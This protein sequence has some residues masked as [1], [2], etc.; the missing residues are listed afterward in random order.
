MPISKFWQL[1]ILGLHVSGFC[2]LLSGPLVGHTTDS[3]ATLWAY[4]GEGKQVEFRYGI[5]GT[6]LNEMT[7]VLVPP[8]PERHFISRTD[9][10]GLTSGVAYQ[11]TV[12]VDGDSAGAGSFTTA[13]APFQPVEFTFLVASCIDRGIDNV[14]TTWDGAHNEM[15]AFSVLL[16]DNVYS[17]S[18]DR[19]VIWTFNTDQ[20]SI[21][22]FANVIRNFPTYAIWDDHD[23]ADNDS[24]GEAVGKENSYKAFT[25]L[26]ANPYYGVPPDTGIYFN[27]YWGNVQ[28]FMLDGRY[29]RSPFSAPD[30]EYKT[31]LGFTQR[32]W[33]FNELKASRAVFKFISAGSTID[34]RDDGWRNYLTELGIIHNYI[35]S[36][37]IY[38]VVWLSGD[39]HENYFK[40]YSPDMGYTVNEI[41]SSGIS[42]EERS[43][44]YIDVNTKAAVPTFTARLI[45]QEQVMETKTLTLADLSSV[46]TRA[47]QI[48][49]P[50][51]GQQVQ[52]AS[53]QDINWTTIGTIDNVKLAYSLGGVWNTIQPSLSNTGIYS[54]LVPDDVSA[55]VRISVSNLD[56]SAADT[57]DVFEIIS[58]M[59]LISSENGNHSF[60]FS[61]LGQN[62]NYFFIGEYVRK[63]VIYETSGKLVQT[64]DVSS[65]HVVWDAGGVNKGLYLIELVGPKT[66][67]FRRVMVW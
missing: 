11:Y 41:T 15:P 27:F 51:L 18:T 6:S 43:I 10:T 4:A 52:V 46:D 66:K 58:G 2:Q 34:F 32:E 9:F 54:W 40:E 38:G 36:N 49:L 42:D 28:V 29:H 56:G 22:K 23:Y 63:V 20:R 19:E 8:D 21:E 65:N 35:A 50:S 33:L 1:I 31:L 13:P 3:S 45:D 17:N 30:D 7:A 14:Q 57:T 60:N 12:M 24:D 67:E 44:A 62:S 64:F 37:E 47:L 55:S 48:Y 5:Q 16:G 25:E 61:I 26:W 39:S 59:D 53:L